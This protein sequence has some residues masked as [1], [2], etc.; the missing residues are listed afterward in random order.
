VKEIFLEAKQIHPCPLQMYSRQFFKL[1]DFVSLF[2]DYAG[3]Y[4]VGELEKFFETAGYLL[5]KN[6]F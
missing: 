1:P 4:K 3:A 6:T 5:N 2:C